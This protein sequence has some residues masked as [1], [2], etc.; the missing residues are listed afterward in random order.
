MCNAGKGC[1]E[2]KELKGRPQDCS[3]EQIRKCHGD[4]KKHPCTKG[5]IGAAHARRD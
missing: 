2:P 1:Q 5:S 4:A 3:A